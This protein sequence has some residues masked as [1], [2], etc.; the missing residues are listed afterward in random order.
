MGL[1]AGVLL[2]AGA[3]LTAVGGH[4]APDGA[5]GRWDDAFSAAMAPQRSPALL[6]LFATLSH[7]GDARVVTAVG[8]VVALALWRAQHRLLACAWTVALV[9]NGLFTRLFKAWW[10]RERPLHEHELA[11]VSGHSFPSGHAS[12]S[13]VVGLW[14]ASLACWLLPAAW[15]LPAALLA[16]AT[17]WTVAFSR[18][19]LNVH[20]ASDVLSG[21]LLGSAWAVASALAVRGVLRWQRLGPGAH[22]A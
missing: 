3:G 21:L 15:R 12:A 10:A 11:V 18:V 7:A 13:A 19:V 5:V 1:A 16:C 6:A 20:Y 17:T 4:I 2:A 9:G 14:L 8:V 22:R